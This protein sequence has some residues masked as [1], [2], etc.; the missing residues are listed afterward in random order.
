MT[1]PTL[2]TNEG[3][4]PDNN[5]VVKVNLGIFLLASFPAPVRKLKIERK[6]KNLSREKCHEVERT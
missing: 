5:G 4:N 2:R 1:Q 6:G 3:Q